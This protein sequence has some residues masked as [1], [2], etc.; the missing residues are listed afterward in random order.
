MSTNDIQRILNQGVAVFTV[1]EIEAGLKLV[2][3]GSFGLSRVSLLCIADGL[4]G[5]FY[6]RKIFYTVSIS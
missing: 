5:L 6:H 2:V 3:A 1:D 4:D